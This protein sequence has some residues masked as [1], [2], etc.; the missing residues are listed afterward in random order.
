[1]EVKN[2]HAKDIHSMKSEYNLPTSITTIIIA[3]DKLF[4]PTTTI[5][6]PE[7]KK[8]FSNI[9]DTNR[10]K[11]KNVEDTT[12]IPWETEFQW[13]KGKKPAVIVNSH[14]GLEKEKD[15]IRIA[16]N[17]ISDKNYN[18]QKEIILSHLIPFETDNE[19]MKKIGKFILETVSSNKFYSE[20]YADLYKVLMT[21]Y[22]L[23]EEIMTNMVTEFKNTIDTIRTIDASVDYDGFCECIKEND[24]RKSASAFIMLLCNENVISKKIVL[25]IMNHFQ[26]T[27]IENIDKENKTSF[28]EEITEL[29]FIFVSMGH[30]KNLFMKKKSWTECI[31]PNIYLTSK[32][33]NNEHVSLSSRAIFKHLDLTDILD[34]KIENK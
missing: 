10:R 1:M 13:N 4:Y 32:I 22:T 20:L 9:K 21:K 24:K 23:F 7:N 25:G 34:S 18:S 12:D 30:K 28:I 16:L 8:D 31:I 3:L 6:R 19:E 27:I 33:K 26:T 5:V 11:K 15:N 29:L 2:F 14:V 17:K